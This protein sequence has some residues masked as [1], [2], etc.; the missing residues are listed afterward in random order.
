MKKQVFSQTDLFTE[1]A[2][3]LFAGGGGASTGYE[4]ATGRVMDIAINHSRDAILM[5]KTNH[6]WTEH[7]QADVFEVDPRMA[8]R[9]RPV[10][11]LWASPDC[12]HFSKAKGAPLVDRKIRGLAWV[13]LRW[14]M[15]VR[16]RVIMAEN[17][18]EIQT[19]G[20][21]IPAYREDGSIKGYIPDPTR[22]GE[23]F[24]A[25]IGMLTDGVPADCPA[26]E[27]VCEFLRIPVDGQE[28]QRLV[29]GL[30]YQLEHRELVA[31]DYGA[32]T[33]RKRW[34]MVAR[35]DG[36]PIVWPEPTYS[37]D[38]AAGRK[39]WRS[40]AEIID[41]S[42]PMFSIF[43]TKQ[44]IKK[45][46]GVNAVRPLADNTLRRCIRGVDKFTIRSGRPFLIPTG[47]GERKGQAP[48]VHDI[49]APLST[50][51]SSSMQGLCEPIL[52]KAS[53]FV[54]QGKFQNCPQDINNPLTT[55][56][57]VGAHE[58]VNPLLA[59]VTFS[60]TN[61]SVGL[62]ADQPTH[63]ITSDGKQVLAAAQLMSIGQLRG[64]DRVRPAEDPTPTQVSK[65]E[66]C[67]LSAQLIQYHTEREKENVRAAELTAP[68]Q[69]VDGSNRHGMV[70]ANLV[71]Y[72]STGRAIDV[73]DPL[74]TAT[75]R[76]REALTST[77]LQPIHA[78]GYHGRGNLPTAPVNTITASGGQ[79]MVAAHI[80]EF[81]GQDKGQAPGAPLRT[82]TSCAPFGICQAVLVK[83]EP[84]RDYGRWPEIRQLLNRYCGYSIAD[85]EII[86]LVIDGVSFYIRDI[87]LRMLSP[88]ELYNAMG[89]PP[90]YIIDRDFEGNVYTK[91]KQVARCGN[92]VCPPMAE[93]VIRANYVAAPI[94][95]IT[96]A[97]LAD[98]VA[99]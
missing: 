63:T 65:A 29:R 57:S 17:V 61:G 96:M 69:T 41:W 76:D 92:A 2:V 85:D 13:I 87:L 91:S 25:F 21:L 59:P 23:T 50:V 94:S 86:L 82:I 60:N 19:W 22:K 66:S 67:V 89:F 72:F 24:T 15:D 27:E 84:G 83:A 70:S 38:G 9:G 16:P 12:R 6:P 14:A 78:G 62:P 32:P 95:I 49:E 11:F 46:Y 33:I 93:A 42:L 98:V 54:A 56:T 31:A 47:Y 30:G 5:H 51:V 68:M 71:E 80:V 99:I 90:D 26:L 75:S 18:E 40:A 52:A 77:I 45:R 3:D 7:Y 10:G 73:G 4:L 28:A 88:R 35:C 37:K 8:T 81:K 34:V 55:I 39:K 20:P 64:G 53:P 43:D 44:E 74:H 79:R 1:I 36:L 58:L 97:Q 48:R